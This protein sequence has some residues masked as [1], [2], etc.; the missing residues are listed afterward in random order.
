MALVKA[1]IDNEFRKGTPVDEAYEIIRSMVANQTLAAA[2][3]LLRGEEEA[4]SSEPEADAAAP[5]A[6]LV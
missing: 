3:G 4:P 1:R 5:P 6:K 2:S